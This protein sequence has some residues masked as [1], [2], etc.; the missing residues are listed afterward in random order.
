MSRLFAGIDIGSRSIELA[1]IDEN[2]ETAALLETDTTN[3]PLQQAETLL[4]RVSYDVIMATGYGRNLFEISFDATTVT[5]I[6]AHAR[7]AQ[8]QFSDT[9]TVLDIGGQDSKVISLGKG[10]R[11][12]KF[13]MN[14]RCAA[15]TGKFLEIMSA[16]L[17]YTI[18][19]FGAEAMAAR[20]DITISSMCTVFAESEVTSLIARGNDSREI[21]LGLH[22]SVVRRVSGMLNRVSDSG[23]IVFTG[24]VA[25]NP[26]IVS[27]LESSLGRQVHIP[28]NPQFNGALGAAFIARESL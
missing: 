10:G 13:E 22:K 28:E 11:V 6:K 19:A 14:D 27:L 9:C 17:G 4:G 8:E 7:G 25:R 24:G 20:K 1:V 15:G 3:H 18:E 16:T 2:G 23:D 5:E 12:Q 26:C 21:A